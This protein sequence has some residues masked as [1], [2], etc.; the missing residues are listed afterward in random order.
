MEGLPHL[1]QMKSTAVGDGCLET[2]AKQ[3]DTPQV[4]EPT[5]EVCCGS[6]EEGYL[7]MLI[8]CLALTDWSS[9]NERKARV[10]E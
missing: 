10:P 7:R 1:S 5:A 9:N 2:L 4:P 8:L 6:S 3:Q